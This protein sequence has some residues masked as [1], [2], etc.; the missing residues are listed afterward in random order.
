MELFVGIIVGAMICTLAS[1]ARERW[2][3]LRQIRAL[4][5]DLEELELPVLMLEFPS[6]RIHASGPMRETLD[7]VRE[8]ALYLDETVE[9]IVR[10]SDRLPIRQAI[11]ALRSGENA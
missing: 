4:T 5:Q 7:L 6:R 3:R 11:E 9:S 8:R 10:E 1:L 2:L